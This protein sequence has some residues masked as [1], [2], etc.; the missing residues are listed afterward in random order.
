MV[1]STEVKHNPFSGFQ[2]SDAIG[3]LSSQHIVMSHFFIAMS[4]HIQD[5]WT[6]E[7]V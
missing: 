4:E 2:L 6:D 3:S 1:V 5:E 7:K